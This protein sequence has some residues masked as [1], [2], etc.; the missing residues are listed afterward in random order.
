M[1]HYNEDEYVDDQPIH[2]SQCYVYDEVAWMEYSVLEY[3]CNCNCLYMCNILAQL[4]AI[5]G[6]KPSGLWHGW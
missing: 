1:I 2:E 6:A 4:F 5:Y 3:K